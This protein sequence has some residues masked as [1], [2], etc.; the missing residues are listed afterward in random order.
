MRVESLAHVSHGSR[1]CAANARTLRA[2]TLHFCQVVFLATKPANVQD[3]GN[4]DHRQRHTGEDSHQ[5]VWVEDRSHALPK[6]GMSP[7][8]R[9]NSRGQDD[10]KQA[11]AWPTFRL[12]L[13]PK[14]QNFLSR[15]TQHRESHASTKRHPGSSQSAGRVASEALAD[16]SP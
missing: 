8:H 11:A 2:I 14:V 13:A 9:R 6:H 15:P 1:S 16:A 12:W 10:E 3:E 4:A 7:R 5:Y